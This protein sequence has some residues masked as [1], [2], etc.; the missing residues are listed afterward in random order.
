MDRHVDAGRLSQAV[1]VIAV[2]TWSRTRPGSVSYA[3]K[4]ELVQQLIRSG[5]R[6]HLQVILVPVNLTVARVTNWVENGGHSVPEDKIQERYVRLW[7]LLNDRSRTIRMNSCGRWLTSGRRGDLDPVLV[8]KDYWAVETLRAVRDRFDIEIDDGFDHVQPIVK[9][10]TSLSKPFGLIERFSEDV[11]LL[12][13]VPVEARDAY[14]Q[15]KRNKVLKA[16]TGAVYTAL[17]IDGER[18]LGRKGVDLHWRYPYQSIAGAPHLSGIDT[19]V[20]VEVTV[21]AGPYP[22]N[23]RSVSSMVDDHART[24]DGFPSYDYLK[25]LE[26]ETLAA[27]RTQI[28]KLAMLHDAAHQTQPRVGGV[29][30]CGLG[31]LVRQGRDPFTPR[32]PGGYATSPAFTNADHA[33][34]VR[35]S[36]DQALTWVWSNTKPSLD[37]CIAIVHEHSALL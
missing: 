12:V 22:S 16:C 8:E 9:G 14:G 4:V 3:S 7:F 19:A 11:D 21:M 1:E 28:E 6:V 34:I 5:Y 30:R 18:S 20:R 10:G 15:N 25:P 24:I 33:K 31:R 2:S 26:I 17:S 27:E 37:E 23:R 32:P 35:K 13:P 29:D 36:F